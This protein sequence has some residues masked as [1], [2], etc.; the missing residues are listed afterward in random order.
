MFFCG[1]ERKGR[2]QAPM[3]V[4]EILAKANCVVRSLKKVREDIDV[5]EE[6]C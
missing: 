1:W 4:A 6:D 2:I 5:V 3:G